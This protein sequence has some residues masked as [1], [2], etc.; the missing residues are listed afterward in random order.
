MLNHIN[1]I[2]IG[3]KKIKKKKKKMGRLNIH[4]SSTILID[5]IYSVDLWDLES[6]FYP[7]LHSKG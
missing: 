4:S 5:K 3:L 6:T 7:N 2:E 1:P